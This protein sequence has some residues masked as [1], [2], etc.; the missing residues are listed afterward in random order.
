MARNRSAAGLVRLAA[1]L[2]RKSQAEAR[3]LQACLGGNAG[4][5]ELEP[6][7]AK[8]GIPVDDKPNPFRDGT[9]DPDVC[10]RGPWLDNV[11]PMRAHRARFSAADLA[12]HMFR[13]VSRVGTEA[14]P[15]LAVFGPGD[16]LN[17]GQRAERVRRCQRRNLPFAVINPI[18][19]ITS[20]L[21]VRGEGRYASVAIVGRDPQHLV[22][23]VSA[24][25]TLAVAE[26]GQLLIAQDDGPLRP[27]GQPVGSPILPGSYVL[28]SA[29]ES[30]TVA[31]LAGCPRTAHGGTALSEPANPVLLNGILLG[32]V[33]AG[34]QPDCTPCEGAASYLAATAGR[35]IL[36]A[37][38]GK[39][40]KSPHHVHDL[41]GYALRSGER[42]P[43]L[44][45]ARDDLSARRLL[46]RVRG[47]GSAS[48]A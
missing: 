15:G 29:P 44:I 8:G 45:V 27:P 10:L 37:G 42:I 14:Q 39:K 5:A 7:P 43:G 46:D 4:L 35:V 12:G 19:S 47:S 33:E 6:D 48:P 11:V 17:D 9:D 30:D 21:G 38:R 32:G 26:P 25:P 22:V 40:L 2:T 34:Y 16:G 28:L 23:A 3:Y 24:G 20:F 41:L 13:T 31:C 1:M 18:D 36:D